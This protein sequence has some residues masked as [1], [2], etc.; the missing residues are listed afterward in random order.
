MTGTICHDFTLTITSENTVTKQN[1]MIGRR[2]STP[3]SIV[4]RKSVRFIIHIYLIKKSNPSWNGLEKFFFV[5]VPISGH[6][7]HQFYLYQRKHGWC[8]ERMIWWRPFAGSL[9]A[10][11]WTHLEAFKIARL[12]IYTD[13]FRKSV[14]IYPR[15]VPDW[16]YYLASQSLSESDSHRECIIYLSLLIQ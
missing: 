11:S 2:G 5:V 8:Q 15:S 4:L 10:C 14:S 12:G 3:V 13:W 16:Q 1:N 7:I 9:G 6:Q